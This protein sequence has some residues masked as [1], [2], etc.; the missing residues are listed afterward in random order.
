[1]F[2]A[3][4]VYRVNPDSKKAPVTYN[5]NSSEEVTTETDEAAIAALAIQG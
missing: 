3:L 2:R 1:M 4:K 5:F